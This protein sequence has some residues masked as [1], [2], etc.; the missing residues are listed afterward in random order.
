MVSQ[1]DIS[2]LKDGMLVLTGG[3]MT[4]IELAKIVPPALETTFYTISPLVAI[5]LN[6]H[7]ILTVNLAGSQLSK[8]AHINIVSSVK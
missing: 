6:K 8:N 1:K 5:A 2:L 4:M 7:T 3:G